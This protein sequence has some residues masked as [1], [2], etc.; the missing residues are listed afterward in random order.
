MRK[1][2]LSAHSNGAASSRTKELDLATDLTLHTDKA[3]GKI[4]ECTRGMPGNLSRA[5]TLIMH[6]IPKR[7]WT[8][9]II[10]V[11]DLTLLSIPTKRKE[12]FGSVREVCPETYRERTRLLCI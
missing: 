6:L 3:K 4:R 5:D 9:C 8:R 12:R 2:I 1:T 10:S 7:H 11:S